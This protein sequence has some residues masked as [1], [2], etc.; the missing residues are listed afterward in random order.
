MSIAEPL[1]SVPTR[2]VDTFQLPTAGETRF[3]TTDA[4]PASSWSGFVQTLAEY[5]AAILLCLVILTVVMKLWRID[6]LIPILYSEDGV[7]I[8]SWIK[9]VI[10]HGWYLHNPQLGM[11]AGQEMY[12]FPLAEGLHF[13]FLKL[14]G[15]VIPDAGAVFNI[16]YFLTFPLATISALFV[17]R[18]LGFS[19]PLG[20]T[21]SLIFA[22]A[23][24]HFFRIGHLFLAAYYL[25]PFI[26][27][28]VLRIYQG[29]PPFFRF[30]QDSG[31][32]RWH[33]RSWESLGT[34]VLALLIGAGGVYYAFFACF[35]L[36][37][38]GISAALAY[39]RLAALV[40]A[41]TVILLIFSSTVLSLAPSIYY[42]ETHEPNPEPVRRLAREAD[43]H[44]FRVGQLVLPITDHRVPTFNH[45][46]DR[47]N[48]AFY[49]FIQENDFAAL[50][51]VASMGFVWLLARLFLRRPSLDG[52]A[53]EGGLAVLNGAATF[54]ATV[55]G[56]GSLFNFLVSPWIRCYNRISIFIGFF[57][58]IA[59]G[60]L[61]QRFSYR[62]PARFRTKT[63]V[64][65]FVASAVFLATLDQTSSRFVPDYDKNKTAFHQDRAFVQQIEAAVP[66]NSMIFQLPYQSFPEG[67][68]VHKIGHYDHLRM[69]LHSQS[70]RWSFGAMKGREADSWQ[71]QLQD[72]PLDFLVKT[73]VIHGFAG[74]YL[75]RN[76]YAYDGS[77]IE[78]ELSAL[79][80]NKPLVSAS[81][82]MSFFSLIDYAQNLRQRFSEND[83][84]IQ[85]QAYKQ[86]FGIAW[87]KGFYHL[88]NSAAEGSWRWSCGK[89]EMVLHNPRSESK[90]ITFRLR[91]ANASQTPA[92][93]RLEGGL[94]SESLDFDKNGVPFERTLIVPP[95]DHVIRMQC[96]GPKVQS[97]DDFRILVFRI[98]NFQYWE[99]S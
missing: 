17:L 10:D 77:Q 21:L 75:D 28:I 64:W 80:G 90:R 19:H 2:T 60:L 45:L 46:K 79:I 71:K 72:R 95:G 93:L 55:G 82:T 12:E 6:L 58:L 4:K 92:H 7:L 14:I 24:Y 68:P 53:I 97:D 99:E 42:L 32:W 25:V 18:R 35:F 70:L 94:L 44:G 11:P 59:V 52:R 49:P 15:L 40:S 86:P 29:Q 23:P 84:Q 34:V 37:I 76:G 66:P 78:A 51:L 9:G 5:G 13:V 22:F 98:C 47:F 57:S 81:G 1:T 67:L 87:R 38:A 73:L 36:A 88:E 27:L 83:W 30:D 65:S 54:L 3:L 69:F 89:G 62:I 33:W 91:F 85:E 96:E 43:E 61:V 16:Y 20:L 31:T 50:G 8:Q 48:R 39:K 56:V 74:I 41:M 63:W 26:V